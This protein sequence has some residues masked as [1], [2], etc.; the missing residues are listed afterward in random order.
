MVTTEEMKQAR[1]AYVTD[2]QRALEMLATNLTVTTGNGDYHIWQEVR[3]VERTLKY[4]R[5]LINE[6]EEE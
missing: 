3:N 2:A 6:G 1:L 4:I 5:R